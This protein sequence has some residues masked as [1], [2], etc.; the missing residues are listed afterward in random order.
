MNSR[1]VG[2]GS[3]AARDVCEYIKGRVQVGYAEVLLEASKRG[4]DEDSCELIIDF[5]LVSGKVYEPKTG[6]L[7][8]VDY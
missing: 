4:I 2:Y 5:L 3:S 8:F 7:E 6:I 1:V